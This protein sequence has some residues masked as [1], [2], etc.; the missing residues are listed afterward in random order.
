MYIE[1]E[2]ERESKLLSQLPDRNNNK[3][4]LHCGGRK[5]LVCR[6]PEVTGARQLE[7]ERPRRIEHQGLVRKV[8]I[9]LLFSFLQYCHGDDPIYSIC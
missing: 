1:A 7:K 2:R 5:R 3:K 9:A 6:T 4:E 8:T